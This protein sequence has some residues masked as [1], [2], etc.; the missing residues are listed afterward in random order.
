MYSHSPVFQLVKNINYYLITVLLLIYIYN[1]K[2]TFSLL[3][4]FLSNLNIVSGYAIE[5]LNL[6]SYTGVVLDMLLN[7]F[8]NIILLIKILPNVERQNFVYG[9]LIFCL[10]FLSNIMNLYEDY[11]S[12]KTQ[13]IINKP[14]LSVSYYNKTFSATLSQTEI[15]LVLLYL[16]PNLVYLWLLH[17]LVKFFTSHSRLS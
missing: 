17:Y 3:Y 14:T 7:K 6:T 10:N 4:I 11:V 15:G 8:L 12:G 9:S 16:M 1:N 13:N 2:I 5:C